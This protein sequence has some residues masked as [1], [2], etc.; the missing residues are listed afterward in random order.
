[1]ALSNTDILAQLDATVKAITEVSDLGLS[2]LQP[3]KATRFIQEM[4]LATRLLP[5]ARVI[6]MRAKQRDIDR[7]AL[8]GRIIQSG[9]DAAGVH[10]DLAADGSDAADPI[11]ANNR[12]ITNE[13]VAMISLRDDTLRENI[14][15]GQLESTLLAL[16]A[17][18]AGRDFE[19]Y[20]TFADSDILFATDGMLSLADGWVKLA[21][22]KVYGEDVLLQEPRDFDPGA[23]TFPENMFQVMLDALPKKYF[24]NP[25]DWRYFVDFATDDAYRDL[26]R[27]RG[28]DLGDRSQTQRQA[29]FYK[30][31]QV[32]YVPL[33]ERA[34]APLVAPETDQV[35]GRVALLVNPANLVWGIFHQVQIEQE[36][37]AKKRRTDFV[38]T[39]EADMDYEDESAAV[40]A[41]LDA[42]NPALA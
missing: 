9:K 10:V 29:T 15:R 11:F 20:A 22:Q 2:V 40:A 24:N 35:H 14:E 19:E 38:L 6:T 28:T 42:A 7:I 12:L 27:T 36:R 21:A 41:L 31:I 33:F 13:L 8:S 37:E 3:E 1:M 16:F 18:A 34:R 17:E 4:Q 30:G 23:A 32:E 25:S 26:L 39:F 5:A